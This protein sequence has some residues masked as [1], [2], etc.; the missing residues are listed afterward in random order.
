[1]T[2]LSLIGEY[3][4]RLLLVIGLSTLIGLVVTALVLNFLWRKGDAEVR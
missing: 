3:G 4:G 2:H 1:M